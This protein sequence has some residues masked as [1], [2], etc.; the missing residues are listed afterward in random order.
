M[1]LDDIRV[2]ELGQL[3]AG[4]FCGQLLADFGAD[5]IKVEPPGTG[6]PI[7]QWGQSKAGGKSLWWPVLGRNK[8]TIT[9]NL[10][11]PEGQALVR[12]LPR[13]ADV[14]VENFRVGT[15]E[16]WGLS[17]EELWK[18]NPRLIITRV[19]GY[20]QDGPY[21]GRAGYGSIGEAM[22]GIRYTTGSPEA[23]PSRSG[24]SLGDELAAVFAMI[25][26]LVALHDRER[27]GHGQIVDSAIYES[28]FAMME[29]LIPEWQVTGYTRE[30]TGPTLPGVAPSNV[31]PTRHG[32]MVLI[33]ANQD[34][35]FGRLCEAMGRE[36]LAVD[37]RFV[38]HGARGEHMEVLDSLIAAWTATHESDALLE[39]LHA[40]GIPAGL[41]YTAKDMLADPHF[42]A[43]EAIIT[44]ADKHLGEIKMQNT[45]PKLSAS[46]GRVR[47]TG[48]DLG[49]DNSAVYGDI[50]NL[51]PEQISALS[52]SGII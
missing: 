24:I 1:A 3:L 36:E 40:A 13:G 52:Q 22:G 43:R 30:R 46:P 44:I 6:D 12:E 32:N 25:G 28:V 8:R 27:T 7:R 33:A 18:I 26:T 45:F 42:A 29:S 39:K 10:R 48:H 5:V 50:L 14:L 15:L 21:S 31:Y 2:V 38:D 37:E 16:R 19:T 4:P 11:V 20:G 47:H 17:P 35:V 9:C 49:Q 51:S 23:P 34:T 41:I